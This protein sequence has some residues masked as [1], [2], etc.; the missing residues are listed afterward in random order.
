[1]KYT[2]ERKK[3]KGQRKLSMARVS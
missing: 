2:L 3:L 1:M